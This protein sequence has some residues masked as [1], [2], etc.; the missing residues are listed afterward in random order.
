MPT[1]NGLLS[2]HPGGAAQDTSPAVPLQHAAFERP[3]A[4]NLRGETQ[5][6]GTEENVEIV[7]SS[8]GPMLQF[9][10]PKPNQ[11]EE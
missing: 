9:R 7:V 11:E 8:N 5:A 2:Q 3:C 10:K 1:K 4:R 6:V